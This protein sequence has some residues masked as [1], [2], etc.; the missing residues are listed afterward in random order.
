MFTEKERDY[1]R[2]QR[3]ARLATV[4]SDG[5]PDVAAVSF[6]FGGELFYIGG[7]NPAKTRRH[8]NVREGNAR[9]ALVIDVLES[10]GRGGRVGSGFTDTRNWLSGR[11][12]LGGANICASPRRCH[13]VGTSQVHRLSA[14][15]S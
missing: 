6:E 12:D 9:V 11:D 7:H 14:E 5:Q 10:V 1:I 2:S 3:L 4:S 13:G 15:N 8:Q